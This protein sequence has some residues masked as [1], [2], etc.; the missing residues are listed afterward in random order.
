MSETLLAVLLV[1][2]SAK[3]SN[4]VYQWPRSPKPQARL[5]RPL[6]SHDVT[7]AQGDNP[8]RAANAPDIPTEDGQPCPGYDPEDEEDYIWKRPHTLRSR[9]M[10]F[11]KSRSVPASRRASPSKGPDDAYP[12]DTSG[13]YY[14]E[15][16]YESVLGYSLEILAGMLCPTRS[17]CHQKFELVVDDLAFIGHPVCADA[18][19]GWRFNEK[20]KQPARGRGTKKTDTPQMEEKAL[21]PNCTESELQTFHFVLVLDLPDPS[22]SASGNISKYFDT[23][24]EQVAFTV[25]AVLYQEQVLHNFVDTESEKLSAFKEDYLKRGKPFEEYITDALKESSLASAMKTLY[26]AIK[27]NTV[28]RFTLHDL[29]LELQLP[30]YLD[31]L[32]HVD[33]DD[34]GDIGDQEDEYGMPN[35]WGPDVSFAWRLPALTPWKALLKLDEDE[36][37]YELYMKVK[38][39]Q[40]PE[41]DR[42]L[43]EQLVRFLEMASATIPLA[44]MASL[45]DWDLESQVYPI[46]RWLVLHRR[47]KLIDVVHPVLKTIFSV[48]QKLPAKILEE[49]TPEFDRTFSQLNVPTLPKLLSTI[50][51][52][53]HSK[54]A[55]HFYATVV[56][57]KD[58]IGLY[59]DVVV[60]LLKRDLLITLHLHIRIVATEELKERVRTHWEEARARRRRARARAQG[61]IH[62]EH[63]ILG[64]TGLDDE[65][66]D[67]EGFTLETASESS[68]VQNWLSMSPKSARRQ[69]RR[70]SGSEKKG[71]SRGS[72]SV[73]RRRF[74]EKDDVEEDELTSSG[75]EEVRWENWTRP[76][77]NNY[78]ASVITDPARATPLERR[79]LAAMSEGKD[80]DIVRRFEKINQYFD[81]KCTD[82]EILFRA[83]ISRKQLRE[84]LHHYEEYLLTFL[85]PS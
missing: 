83:E 37:A 15:D 7:C 57:A 13:D 62:D 44:D 78:Y 70:I 32:L 1:T 58:L 80:P 17:M 45:L 23:I 81:G 84:V 77:Y 28:A 10:S 65:N 68:P 41:E 36:L 11:S 75:E 48:P 30:P 34:D 31:S 76:E 56:G 8:W 5:S 3:G 52:S 61:I 27:D 12:L 73:H 4:L 19:G 63:D 9:S 2:S 82:D 39:P 14:E 29:P 42:D 6:P 60:W 71:G 38:A 85:H 49:L 79:W 24:Y 43:A 59:S 20:A 51:T 22:S 40:L 46:V 66:A 35:A 50:S 47:A 25:T 69:S 26:D 16:E 33:E 53:T 18:D 64:T 74:E 21:E 72:L 67:V 55:N 54:G